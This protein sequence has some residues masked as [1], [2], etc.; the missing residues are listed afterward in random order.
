M[1]G[2]SKLPGLN[3][4]LLAEHGVSGGTRSYFKQLLALYAEQ[5]TQVTVVR[6]Y[7]YDDEEIGLLCHQYGFSRI[8]QS[9]IVGD[10]NGLRVNSIANHFQERRRFR[11]FVRQ[12]AADVVVA[13]VGTPELFLGVV[14]LG[15]RAIYIR[16]TYPH[17][18]RNIF[19]RYLRRLFYSFVI[20]SSTR[21]LTVSRYSR[22][23]IPQ[24]WGLWGRAI[25]VEVIY[26]T[27]GAPV[28]PLALANAGVI[29][30]LTVGHAVTYK[31]PY[32]WIKVAILLKQNSPDFDIRLK[33]VGDG[34]RL[35]ECRDS[36]RALGAAIGQCAF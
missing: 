35:D 13:A 2:M 22:M 33:G 1:T 30:L 27:V 12:A 6:T 21:I 20:Y 19:N 29:N 7:E 32:T 15:N 9:S 10:K 24:A 36:V 3:I 31:N 8:E 14:N 25:A 5:R 16:H 18:S 11:H 34:S 4:L 28:R 23:R 17:V 26:S